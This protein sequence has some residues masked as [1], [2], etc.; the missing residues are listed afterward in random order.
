MAGPLGEATGGS[1]S[2]HIEV[3]EDIDG[4]PLRGAAGGF[5]SGHHQS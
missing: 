3:E 2:G 1:S 5:G 4:G